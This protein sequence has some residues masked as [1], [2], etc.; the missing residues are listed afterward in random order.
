[1]NDNSSLL[2]AAAIK[3]LPSELDKSTSISHK[4]SNAFTCF[5]ARIEDDWDRVATVTANMI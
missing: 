2:V 5:C 3:L 1:M 4:L